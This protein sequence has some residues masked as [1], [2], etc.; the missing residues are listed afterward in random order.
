[1]HL[2]AITL[3]GF[4]TFARRTEI[5]FDG[6]MVAIVGPNGSGKSNIVD[7]F[8]WVLGETQAKDIRGRTMEEVI[9]AGGERTPRASQAE[10]ALLLDNRDGRLPIDY[11]E[12]ELKRRVERGGSSDYFLNGTRVRRR[13]LMQL[14]ASTGLT[15][16][17]YSIINQGDIELIVTSSPEQRRQ[18]VEEAAQVRGVKQQRSEAA[19]K[20]S[21]LAQNLLRLEDVRQELQPRLEGLA[22]QAAAAREA[23]AAEARLEVLRGSIV[24]EEWREARDSHRKAA[25]Q[26]QSLE[27]RLEEAL[28]LA[29]KAEADFRA[30][31]A[32][33]ESAQDRRLARQQHLG[34]LR[35]EVQTAEHTLALARQNLANLSETGMALQNELRELDARAR[36][37]AAVAAQLEREVGSA[38]AALAAVP[39]DPDAPGRPDPDAARKAAAD[40]E[41]ARREVAQALSAVAAI[42][43]RRQ[44][45]EETAGRLQAQVLP[46]EEKLPEIEARAIQLTEGAA[47]AASAAGELVRIRAEL[48]GLEALWPSPAP[49]EVRVGDVLRPDPGYEAALSAVLGHL[50]EAWVA[51]DEAGAFTA[52]EGAKT[53]RTV[54]V[55][56]PGPD[57]LKGSL[58][59]HVRVESG[60]EWLARRLL[61]GVRLGDGTGPAV[62]LEGQY[63]DGLV[64]RAGPDQRVRLAS[65]RA[66]LSDRIAEIEELAAHAAALANDARAADLEAAVLRSTADGR[67]RLEETLAQLDGTRKAEA[68]ANTAL[69]ALEAAAQ[70]AADEADQ[71]QRAIH[72]QE[73]AVAEVQAECRRLELER[74]R[75]ADRMID[76]N[77]Q[78]EATRADLLAIESAGD[79]RRT[80]LGETNA[81]QA[82]AQEALGGL[83]QAVGLALGLLAEAENESP[84]GEAELA[85]VARRLVA[86][87][88][89]RVDGRLRSR[90]L[91]GNL[92]LIAREVELLEARM[93]EIRERMPMGQAP[94][95]VPGGKSREREMRQLERQLEEIGPTNPLAESE[96]SELS[97]RFTMLHEQLAD[98]EAARLDLEQLVARLRE[99]EDSRYATVFGAVAAGF[100]EYFAEL[101]AG[102]KA[103]LAH[104]PGDDGPRSGVEIL[105]Q[106]PRKKLQNITLLSSGERSLTALALVLALEEVNP[107][108]FMILD[109]VDAALDDANVGRYGDLLRRLGAR[110]QLLVITHNHVTM[111]SANALYGVHLDESG[112]SS[113]VS[114]NLHDIHPQASQ[115]AASA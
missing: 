101:T 96:H 99:E 30:G 93:E 27:K 3:N 17:S 70:A 106:P 82:A 11:E 34:A 48:E 68:E 26:K 29:E 57:P 105:V 78:L 41:H 6:G 73:K 103:T 64:R 115:R 91:E 45:L 31:R 14:L 65:R 54:L 109:E 24:W 87:E 102:G 51:S 112:R 18:L 46:A 19:A 97:A 66:A 61:G 44:F 80:R 76:L 74:L 71:R 72:E 39:I 52:L 58:Y 90:T 9:Y 59:D 36:T 100:Q 28:A 33:M 79:A 86:V 84:G 77:R 81:A 5:R 113:L 22:T 60:Y 83:E 53:Q 25:A 32:E 110:R 13:D 47:R 21:D 37:A 67:A 75:W 85:E 114:V 108:P 92:E 15:T 20:L 4:K 49:G 7:A 98:I 62:S 94:E 38:E 56:D 10:V 111:A 35:L 69:P 2:R 40:S 23:A 43:T 12:V 8:K 55:P 63:R 42:R 50:V 88:E 1:V 95:E 104:V 16:D 89:A 107:S